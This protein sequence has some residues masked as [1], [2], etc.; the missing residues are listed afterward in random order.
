TAVRRSVLDASRRVDVPAKT[1]L[2]RPGESGRFGLLVRGRVRT[3]HVTEEG[4]ELTT[5][6]SH[7]G[8]IINALTL[9][10]SDSDLYIQ[11]VT[12]S[13]WCDFDVET[14]R[15]ILTTD[16]DSAWLALAVLEDRL[17]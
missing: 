17:R 14:V 3:M 4:H 15:R 10:G 1:Y 2:R 7:P 9:T 11:A 5:T 12:A 6:W 8:A 16:V 13:V